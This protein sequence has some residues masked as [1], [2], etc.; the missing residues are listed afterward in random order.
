MSMNSLW[1]L[2]EKE[3]ATIEEQAIKEKCA[4]VQGS[5]NFLFT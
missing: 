2:I 3:I 4:N 1:S 5:V